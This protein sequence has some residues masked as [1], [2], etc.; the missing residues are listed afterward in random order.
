MKVVKTKCHGGKLLKINVLNYFN[1]HKCLFA[2]NDN[3][4][5]VCE[6]CNSVIKFTYKYLHY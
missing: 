6:T 1:I 5:K 2:L 3:T 4:I